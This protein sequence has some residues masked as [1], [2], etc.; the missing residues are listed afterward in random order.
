MARMLR[1]ALG[2]TWHH[3]MNRGARRLPVFGDDADRLAFL[4]LLADSVTTAEVR[5]HAYALM[6]NHF[7]LLVEA[8][9][10]KLSAAMKGLTGRYAQRF[11]IKYGYDG[12][13]FR[14]RY[15]SKPVHDD[16]HLSATLR[17]IHRNP[18][19][20]GPATPEAFRWTS[21]LAYTDEV[22]RPRWL[23][24][25]RLLDRFPSRAAYIDFVLDATERTASGPPF[26]PTARRRPQMLRPTDVEV[27]LGVDSDSEL[28]VVRCGGRGVRNDVRLALLYLASLHTA[29]PMDDLCQRYGYGSVAVARSAV[30][31]AR[32][33]LLRDPIFAE[34]V[35]HAS[36]RLG[37]PSTA[38]EKVWVSDP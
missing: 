7:H 37:R 36:A 6:P 9:V 35:D 15:R 13:L 16:A 5:V 22:R 11:N 8:E 31:R 17:Y 10:P 25:T 2:G 18:I 20:D 14:S 38:A 33:R 34:L 21:H 3:V 32:R 28:A 26:A 30:A 4:G 29:V 19:V 12:P 1:S 23:T 27:A 24:T